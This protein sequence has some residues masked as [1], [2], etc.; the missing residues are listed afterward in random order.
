MASAAQA[1]R[2]HQVAAQSLPQASAAAFLER[3]GGDCSACFRCPSLLGWGVTVFL[4]AFVPMHLSPSRAHQAAI[5]LS[6]FC[7]YEA[8]APDRPR[9][10]PAESSATPRP[11]RQ[12]GRGKGRRG[13]ISC[14]EFR[15]V[16]LRKSRGD[17]AI[18]SSSL[19]FPPIP[20]IPR[21]GCSMWG[22]QQ[23]A[24]S[25]PRRRA[26]Q[27]MWQGLGTGPRERSSSLKCVSKRAA[28]TAALPAIPH[29]VL[30]L[31]GAP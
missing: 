15:L 17:Q 26:G 23:G 19:S 8:G 28:V 5:C 31:P 24:A 9:A 3:G 6:S 11:H 29:A 30:R 22:N 4:C 12:G 14:P 16:W 27:T 13:P 25:R 20:E 2:V 10:W 1:F 21:M 7:G 18:T